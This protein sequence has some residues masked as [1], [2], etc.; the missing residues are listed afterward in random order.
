MGW[1]IINVYYIAWRRKYFQLPHIFMSTTID[2]VFRQQ[3]YLINAGIIAAQDTQVSTRLRDNA[4][5][6]SKKISTLFDPSPDIHHIVGRSLS[7]G[8][9][10]T[11]GLRGVPHRND[12]YILEW[13]GI[14]TMKTGC[15]FRL[16]NAIHKVQSSEYSIAICLLLCNIYL[17]LIR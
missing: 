5:I 2:S 8:L 9:H 12:P 17:R 7:D 11:G 1:F 4:S 15:I 10:K 14:F 3:A 13:P 6:L 16:V